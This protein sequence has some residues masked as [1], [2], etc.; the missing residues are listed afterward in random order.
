MAVLLSTPPVHDDPLHETYFAQAAG[1]LEV[2]QAGTG[3]ACVSCATAWPCAPAL[4][5]AFML[6]LHSA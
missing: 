4:A 2:H 3:H 6:E 1:A 5:A